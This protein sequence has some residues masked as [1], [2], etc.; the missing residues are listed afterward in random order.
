MNKDLITIIIPVYNVELYLNR[1]IESVINQ[2]Y[3]DIEIILINDGSTDNSEEI[4]NKYAKRD[5]RI[6]VINKKNGGLSDARNVGIDYSSGNYLFFLDSDDWLSK[7]AIEILYNNIIKYNADISIGTLKDVFSFDKLV[8]SNYKDLVSLY[9]KEEALENLMYM[10]GFGNSA[11]GKLFKSSLFNNIRFP[12]RKLYED[13]ATVYKIFSKSDKA[14][15]IDSEIYFY[16]QNIYSIMHKKYNVNRLQALHFAKE[17]YNFIFKNF[18][19]ILPSARYRLFFE[20]VCVM[21]D[22]PFFCKDKKF[23]YNLLKEHRKYV[24]NDKKIYKKQRFICYSSFFGQ[25]G[26]KICFFFRLILKRR[27]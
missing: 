3:K 14:V 26:I 22:M 15:L 6:S 8:Y 10:H 20:C 7:N 5:K 25:L 19:E 2:T 9:S 17:E 4:C 18:K 13:L 23:V 27:K 16:Y 12:Y 21:N 24:V 11:C 1:C